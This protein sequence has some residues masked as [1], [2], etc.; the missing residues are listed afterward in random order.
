MFTFSELFAAELVGP[1][2]FGGI[3]HVIILFYFTLFFYFYFIG[4]TVRVVVFSG[5]FLQPYPQL[6]YRL[7]IAPCKVCQNLHGVRF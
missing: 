2:V 3:L 6:K 1:V 5:L 4:V 7:I